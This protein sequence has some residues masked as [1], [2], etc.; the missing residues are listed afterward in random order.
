MSDIVLTSPAPRPSFSPEQISRYFFVPQLDEDGEPTSVFRC[1]VCQWF[2]K[3]AAG[4]GY[5]NLMQHVRSRHPNFEE[6]MSVVAPVETGSMLS[7]V[8]HKAAN[9]FN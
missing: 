8:S 3:Q 1:K 2:Y 9:R 6:E 5:R 4:R 7:W